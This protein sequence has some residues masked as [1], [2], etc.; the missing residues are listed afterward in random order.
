MEEMEREMMEEELEVLDEEYNR[1][2][3]KPPIGWLEVEEL[4][5]LRAD[6]NRL[7]AS[8]GYRIDVFRAIE[9]VMTGSRRRQ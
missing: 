4:R 7:R 9:H 1:L 3:L 8:L 6:V 5:Q 2:S